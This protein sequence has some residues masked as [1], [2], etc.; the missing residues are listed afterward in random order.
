VGHWKIYHHQVD[1]FVQEL[2]MVEIF[3]FCFISREEY[4]VMEI[5]LIYGDVFFIKL[6]YVIIFIILIVTELAR[7]LSLFFESLS[8]RQV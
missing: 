4:F 2:M 1:D 8:L 5:L 3:F 6:A 7:L